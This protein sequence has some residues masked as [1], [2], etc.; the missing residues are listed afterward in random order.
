M[1]VGQDRWIE[2]WEKVEGKMRAGEDQRAMPRLIK[3]QES[4]YSVCDVYARYEHV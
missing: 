3:A 4:V 1:R 2:Q